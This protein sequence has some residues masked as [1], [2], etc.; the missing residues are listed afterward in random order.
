MVYCFYIIIQKTRDF[1]W[2]YRHNKPQLID[3][4]E[5]AH[6]FGYYITQN[7]PPRKSFNQSESY[8]KTKDSDLFL[9][10]TDNAINME[11]Y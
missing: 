3:Q 1:P 5:H 6:W 8:L 2:V 4:S 11:E 9:K 10:Q 7:G